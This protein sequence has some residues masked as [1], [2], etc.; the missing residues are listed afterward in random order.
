LLGQKEDR[1]VV[2]RLRDFNTTSLLGELSSPTSRNKPAYDFTDVLSKRFTEWQTFET[3]W[4]AADLLNTAVAAN[5]TGQYTEV[6]RFVLENE[7]AAP[8]GLI[9]LSKRILGMDLIAANPFGDES[10]ESTRAQIH[11]LR[12]R[13]RDEVRNAIVWTELARLYASV[14]QKEPAAR[15]MYTG[16]KLA[17]TN[18]FVLRSAARLFL[19][20]K[21]YGMSLKL[22][23]ASPS[24]ILGDPWLVSAEIAVS[25]AVRGPSAFAKAAFKIAQNNGFSEFSRTELNSA[26]GTLEMDSGKASAARKLFRASLAAPNDN[27]LAQAGFAEKSLG[28]LFIKEEKLDVP[29]SYEARGYFAFNREMWRQAIEFGKQWLQDQPFSTRPATF[30]SFVSSCILEDYG[31]AE[32]S[33]RKA[34]NANPGSP[35]L[36]NNLVFTLASS[37][38]TEEAERELQKLDPANVP[39]LDSVTLTATRGL[40]LMRKKLPELGRQLYMSSMEMAHRYGAY[41]YEAMAAAYLAREELLAGQPNADQTLSLA[42]DKAGKTP[43]PD[44]KAILK[45]VQSLFERKAQPKLG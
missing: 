4:H 29:R 30:V 38:R 24:L 18:R 20:V 17:P 22:L 23:R 39:G 12:L 31:A 44:L 8:E 2:P 11:A 9:R 19:H 35:Q 7:S 32:A 41:K 14:G 40:L 26:L 43:D 6:A 28:G 33:L 45:N 36:V 37:G 25:S 1:K 10:V 13:L 5:L 15:A 27:S 42:L 3:I 34:L 16:Y 21:D